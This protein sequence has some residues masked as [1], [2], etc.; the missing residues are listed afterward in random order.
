MNNY[1]CDEDQSRRQMVWQGGPKRRISPSEGLQ[2]A[3]LEKKY[4]MW[5]RMAE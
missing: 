3:L 4:L 5:D 2:K 1:E